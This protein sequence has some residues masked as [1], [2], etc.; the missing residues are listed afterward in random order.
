MIKSCLRILIVSFSLFSFAQENHKIDSLQFVLKQQLQSTNKTEVNVVNTLNNI[1]VAFYTINKDSCIAYAQKA[2]QYS[3]KNNLKKDEAIALNQWGK[4]LYLKGNYPDAIN[5]YK[6]ALAINIKLNLPQNIAKNYYNIG[7]GYLLLNNYPKALTY[8]NKALK[9]A[10]KLKDNI[11]ISQTYN[12]IAIL[13]GKQ[14]KDSLMLLH[15][16]K[17]L[18]V[19]K[20][21]SSKKAINRKEIV[22]YNLALEY[23]DHNEP[24]KALDFFLEYFNTRQPSDKINIASAAR[25]IGGTYCKMKVYS[26]ALHY[27]QIAIRNYKLYNEKSPLADCYREIGQVYFGMKKYHKAIDFT[28]KGFVISQEIGE[29]ESVKF[30]H[31]NLSKYYV[32][33]KNYKKAYA[34]QF[35]FKKI[36]DSIFNTSIDREVTQLQY[37]FEL[38]KQE[39]KFKTTQIYKD[40]IIAE[41]TK[42]KKLLWFSLAVSILLL[43]S[44]IIGI[45]YTL[46]KS[47][48]EQKRAEQSLKEKEVLLKEIHHRVK[49]NLQIISSILSIQSQSIT[50]KDTLL[51]VEEGQRRIQ[52]MSLIHQSLYQS[53]NITQIDV[54]LYLNELVAYLS[55]LFGANHKNIKTTI[56]ADEVFFDFD[57]AIPLGLIINELVTNIY[58]YAFKDINEGTICIHITT[59][60][61][62]DYQLEVC[63]DGASLP[64]NFDITKTSSFGIKLIHILSRQLRGKLINKSTAN[65]T[66][67]VV[68]FKD[69]KAY[70]NTKKES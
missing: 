20:N 45:S 46:K 36:S 70:N 18:A 69:L 47:K 10:K 64:D 14:D 67:F 39:E 4:C 33:L 8:S 17:A 26:K 28:Q 6:K 50:D 1:S 37:Q 2:I 66:V 25:A 65:K 44:I 58:K 48:K 31:Q 5:L 29:L 7:Q 38:E 62:L 55:D 51:L 9:T 41:E 54:K 61:K 15:F 42:N 53:E 56:D 32:T 30:C 13:Y 63:N 40:N 68:N 49:N 22:Q 11:L 52:A 21:E 19:L 23:K 60:N 27:Y 59:Q 16:K 3:T 24:Q 34:Q 43:S 57:T 35:L 12:N